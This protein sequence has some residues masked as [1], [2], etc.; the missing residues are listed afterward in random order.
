VKLKYIQNRLQ[1]RIKLTEKGL[2]DGPTEFPRLEVIKYH[3]HV[4]PYF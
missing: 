3:A 4:F 2:K 1:E